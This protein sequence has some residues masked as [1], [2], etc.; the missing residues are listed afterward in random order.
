[1]GDRLN[2]AFG[3]GVVDIDTAAIPGEVHVLDRRDSPK[4]IALRDHLTAIADGLTQQLRTDR[5][6]AV[7]IIV[8]DKTRTNPEYPDLLDMILTVVAAEGSVPAVLV[9]AYGTHSPHSASDHA[10]VYGAKNLARVSLVEHNCYNQELLSP[11]GHLSPGCPLKINRSIAQ[12]PFVIGLG[13][14]APHAFAG[15]TGGPKIILP[16]VADYESIRANHAQV[17]SPRAAIGRLEGNPIHE[18]MVRALTLRPV[19][20]AV[21]TVHCGSGKLAGVFFGDMLEAYRS[22]VAFCRRISRVDIAGDADLVIASCGGSPRDDSLYQAQRC[23]AVAVRA[24]KPKGCVLVIGELPRG[25]GNSQLEQCLS[26]QHFSYQKIAPADIQVGMHSAVLMQKELSRATVSF[27]TTL[28]GDFCRRYAMHSLWGAD[29]FREYVCSR[30]TDDAR[31]YV[32]PDTSS[33]L[34]LKGEN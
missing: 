18:E 25:I 10:R 15:F 13:S 30:L 3:T 17:R 11:V 16:G 14:V 34:V 29:A 1:V 4:P 20:F 32:I 19:N 7:A 21:Q 24:V 26:D 9:P 6:S 31:T 12:S 27:Y 23:I 33:C 5:P 8:E 22:A 28:P 2:F